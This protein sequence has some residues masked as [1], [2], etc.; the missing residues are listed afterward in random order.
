MSKS[1]HHSTKQQQDDI[2]CNN[3]SFFDFIKIC[4]CILL[5]HCLLHVLHQNGAEIDLHYAAIHITERRS[6]QG[7]K[8]NELSLEESVYSQVKLWIQLLVCVG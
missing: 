5:W 2:V 6:T 8:K 3:N 7:K 1:R 4:T